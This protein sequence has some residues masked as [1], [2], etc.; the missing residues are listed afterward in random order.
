MMV[1]GLDPGFRNAGW[2]LVD[3][4]PGRPPIVDSCG[5]FTPI[6]RDDD[7]TKC[8]E[9]ETG[10]AE[11]CLAMQRLCGLDP[12]R[13]HL[14]GVEHF[15]ALPPGRGFARGAGAAATRTTWVEG[16]MAAWWSAR[17]IPVRLV[18]PEEARR[19]LLGPKAKDQ[20][21]QDRSKEAMQ[22]SLAGLLGCRPWEHLGKLK[23]E[24]AADAIA[25]A[26]VAAE[27]CQR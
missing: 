20:P 10:L 15:V 12:S 25:V 4:N 17:D 3:V 16:A 27:R 24:H 18:R 9:L 19:L 1:L 26:L 5:T 7:G 6:P 14:V 2:A 23:R 21:D 13:V 8:E 11:I 22:D